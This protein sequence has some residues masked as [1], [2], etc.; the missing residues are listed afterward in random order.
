[1]KPIGPAPL[2][3]TVCRLAL[4]LIVPLSSF[5]LGC[6]G[7]PYA[8]QATVVAEETGQPPS[9]IYFLHVFVDGQ[10]L[11]FHIC[12]SARVEQVNG[13]RGVLLLPPPKQEEYW[14]AVASGYDEIWF[15][16]ER[17]GVAAESPI[18]ATPDRPFNIFH[19]YGDAPS[20]FV[21]ADMNGNVVLRLKR[22]AGT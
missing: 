22:A 1:M 9:D 17:H 4:W 16:V 19:D 11:F 10:N 2:T 20:H 3:T 21:R 15:K 5:L 8:K 7:G 18:S 12:N 13:N 6:E 14:R